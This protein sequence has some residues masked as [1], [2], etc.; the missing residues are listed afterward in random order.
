[1]AALALYMISMWYYLAIEGSNEMQAD[2]GIRE[3]WYALE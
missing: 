2:Y 3:D 1:M